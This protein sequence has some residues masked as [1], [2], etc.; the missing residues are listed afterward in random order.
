LFTFYNILDD[1]VEG[2][3]KKAAGAGVKNI[4]SAFSKKSDY[5]GMPAKQ[6]SRLLNSLGMQWRSHHVFGAPFKMPAGAKGADGK[7]ITLPPIKNLKE[8]LQEIID[9]AQAGGLQYLVAAHLP[10]GASDEIKSSLDILSAS[11]GPCKKAG[12][13]LVYHNE[14]ADFKEIDGK[15]PYET[16]LTQ[17]NPDELK[18]ELDIAWE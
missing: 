18:F 3:L 12:I 7:P 5:Y 15:T 4:E 8:N 6:F 2:T 14:P 11:A 9:D 1:D 13:Q 16:F 17:T 10:I